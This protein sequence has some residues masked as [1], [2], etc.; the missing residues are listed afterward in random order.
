VAGFDMAVSHRAL[1]AE[2]KAARHAAILDAA[3]RLLCAEPERVASVADVARA[4]GVA[5]GTVY[6]YFPGKE[7]LLLALHERN[8]ERFFD[9]LC[10]RLDALEPLAIDAVLAVVRAHVVDDALFLPLAARCLGVMH[11]AIEPALVAAFRGRMAKRLERAGAGLERHF[12]MPAGDGVT[13]LRRSF[14]LLIGLWQIAPVAARG[15]P[16]RGESPAL[17]FTLATEVDA[18]LATLWRGA[19]TPA[20]RGA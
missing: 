2:D 5:K 1:R 15:A 12:A 9:A 6:L 19:T 7:D 20:S 10:A 3:A 16:A 13:L 17:R 14:A 4:A 11:Q 18:A 8:V